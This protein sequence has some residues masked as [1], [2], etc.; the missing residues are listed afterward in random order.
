MRLAVLF[1][2]LLLAA[3]ATA[4]DK[5]TV[6]LDWFINPDHGPLYVAQ[7]MGAFRD[8][9][10]AVELIAPADPNDP[11]SSSPPGRRMSRSATSRSFIFRSPRD[12]LCDG[13]APWWRHRSIRWS[14]WP[15]GR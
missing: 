13:S 15:T 9:G 5:L 2:T 12:C 14:C 1:T 11:R 3:P 7:E 10:L 4:Q 6:M 8:R